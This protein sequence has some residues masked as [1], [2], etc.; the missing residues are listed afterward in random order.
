MQ[1]ELRLGDSQL[2]IADDSRL[3]SSGRPATASPHPAS[4]D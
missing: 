3:S 4:G 2:M 1:I